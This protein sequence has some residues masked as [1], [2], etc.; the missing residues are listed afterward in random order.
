MP[1]GWLSFSRHAWGRLAQ[2]TQNTRFTVFNGGDIQLKTEHCWTPNFRI[3]CAKLVSEN[4]AFMTYYLLIFYIDTTVLRSSDRKYRIQYIF[5]GKSYFVTFIFITLYVATMEEFFAVFTTY[6]F[7]IIRML[8][9]F[10]WIIYTNLVMMC[11]GTL[12]E[13]RNICLENFVCCSFVDR[14]FLAIR[15]ADLTVWVWHFGMLKLSWI[16]MLDFRKIKYRKLGNWIMPY[17][18]SVIIGVVCLNFAYC[19]LVCWISELS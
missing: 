16:R 9:T 7:L 10:E 8:P 2:S 3:A 17:V 13:I 5:V 1:V 19:N 6:W 18:R 14:F 15:F 4:D 11:C 12:Q